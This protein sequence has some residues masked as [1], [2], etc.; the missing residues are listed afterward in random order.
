MLKGSTVL[1]LGLLTALGPL[2]I[3]LY[4]PAFPALRRDLDATDGTVQLTLAAMTLGLAAG[5]LFMGAWSDRVG[6][7]LPLLLSTSVH[8][9]ATIGCALAPSIAVL[10]AFR[11]VQGIGAAGSAVL[12]LAIIRDA[13]DGRALVVLLSRVTLVTTTVPLL[14]PVAGAELLNL[15]G[16]RGIF[17]VLAAASAAVLLAGALGVPETH[18]PSPAPVRLRSRLRAVWSDRAFRRA[19]L[20]A[21]MTYAGVY[22]YVAA[23]PL[24]L[25]EVY[26]LGTRTYSIVFL[27]NSL[28][29]V[30]G[31]Q[32]SSLLTRR[33]DTARVLAGFTAV[34]VLAAVA[35]VP[36]QWA[37]TGTGG[38]LLCLWLF[39]AA[40][41]GCFPC[42]TALALDGQGGQS[43]T[44]TSLH[45]FTNFTA[46]GVISP[47]AGLIGITGPAPVAGVL[48]VTSGIALLSVVTVLRSGKRVEAA[49][50]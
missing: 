40:C 38:L 49:G 32:L 21:A 16:W 41:G 18:V 30:A 20:V 6:R 24:L 1:V 44:A 3:D 11:V 26:G 7:R 29:L 33:W 37:H 5:E 27:V 22:A 23:S 28:G 35:I 42:A 25:Q 12:V 15:A 47:V 17:A 39:V 14:A 10:A 9:A 48:M 45:G 50:R 8:V 34:T 13:A 36:L 43:G 4:L 19:T 31:V 46:A 2:S